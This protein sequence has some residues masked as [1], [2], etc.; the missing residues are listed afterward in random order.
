MTDSPIA[1]D[2]VGP[3]KPIVCIVYSSAD[4]TGAFV[5][6]RRQ[7]ELMREEA[8]WQ[9][10]IPWHSR[11]PDEELTAFSRV[12][13]LPLVELDSFARVA[14][15][16]VTLVYSS[17]LLRLRLARTGCS[18]VQM[19]CFSLHHGTMLRLLGFRGKIVTWVRSDPSR[20]N[21]GGKASLRLASW[22]SSWVVAI[23]AYVRALMPEVENVR[24]TYDPVQAFPVLGAAEE[25]ALVLLGNYIPMKGQDLAIK[26]FHKVAERH[27]RAKLIFH[28]NRAGPDMS[29]DYFRELRSL[30][31][32]GA[33]AGRI[34]F[35]PFANVTD[36][37][38]RKR[39]ALVVSRWEPFGLACQDASGHGLPVIATRSG[40]PEEMVDDGRN[41]FLVDVGD[42]E[43]LA[44]RMD[45]LLSGLE[46][47]RAMGHEGA[48]LMKARFPTDR[49]KQE[50]REIFGL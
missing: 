11:I 16:F 6:I 24:L 36:A 44:D 5:A 41:G 15:Y 28:G 14:W 33:G 40:G 39:A 47:A 22:C 8:E 19:N 13:R 50:L 48:A 43:D 35:E 45:E 12:F 29:E 37:L 17:I 1:S 38:R 18:R 10:A 31:E 4:M 21:R 20:L 49:F 2:A 25:P 9:L 3:Q 32:N 42:I 7:A 26:A 27:P 46:L 30:A 34:F 23:S